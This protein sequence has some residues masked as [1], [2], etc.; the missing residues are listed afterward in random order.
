MLW[1]GLMVGSLSSCKG[2]AR[3]FEHREDPEAAIKRPQRSPQSSQKASAKDIL[4]ISM[5]I[6]SACRDIFLGTP[7]LS[8][9]PLS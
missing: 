4:H 3:G 9:P 6:L 8:R 7:T 5:E 1:F 2:T